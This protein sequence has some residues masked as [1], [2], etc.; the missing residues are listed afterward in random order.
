MVGEAVKLSAQ[1]LQKL[2]EYSPELGKRATRGALTLAALEKILPP[3]VATAILGGGIELSKFHFPK[4]I[5]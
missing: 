4:I 3:T 2:Y 5:I 1:Q